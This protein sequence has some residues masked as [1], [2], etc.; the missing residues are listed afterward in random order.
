MRWTGRPARR[1]TGERGG[2][3]FFAGAPQTGTVDTACPGGSRSALNR[4]WPRERPCRRKK[5]SATD[6]PR[7]LVC[8]F[9]FA[10]YADY[11]D[12]IDL[13]RIV[14]QAPLSFSLHGEILPQLVLFLHLSNQ[15]R[16]VF[17][18]T[19]RFLRDRQFKC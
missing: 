9:F 2:T 16:S 15:L 6:W 18:R 5:G 17:V 12:D 10:W 1:R 8:L 19:L 13:K 3:T 14:Q 11:T 7:N 4:A